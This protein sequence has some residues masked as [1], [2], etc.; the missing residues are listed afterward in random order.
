MK[1]NMLRILLAACAMLVMLI[2]IPGCKKTEYKLTTTGDVNMVGYFDNNPDSFSLFRQIL[3]RTETSAYLNAYGAYTCFAPTNSGV[4]KYLNDLGAADVNAA[5]LATLKDMVRFHLLE[6]TITT[7]QFTD[8]KLPV[9]TMYGQYLITTVVT[10]YGVSGYLVNRQGFI[11][12]PNIKV[13]NGIIHQIDNVLIP[14]KLTIAKTL[15]AKPNYS[16][17]TQA[18]RETGYYDLLNTNN[19]PITAKKWLTVW[20]NQTRR[21]LIRVLQPM[22]R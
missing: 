6:D 20:Q 13:G 17:F 4:R 2:Y 9:V 14:A 11:T 19:N 3:E 22:Q 1:K 15:E 5:D 10:K 8:G 12:K 7:S 16:I 18:M 21:W